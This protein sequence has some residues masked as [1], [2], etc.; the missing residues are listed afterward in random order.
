MEFTNVRSTHTKEAENQASSNQDYK[1]IRKNMSVKAQVQTNILPS[2]VAQTDA[3]DILLSKANDER[4][5]MNR[6]RREPRQT[7]WMSMQRSSNL[8]IETPSHKSQLP[9]T[10]I[11]DCDR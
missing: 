11:T 9:P 3:N 7:L 2:P 1:P 8:Q 4:I 6:Q 5:K 10:D